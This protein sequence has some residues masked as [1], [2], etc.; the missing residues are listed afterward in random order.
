MFVKGGDGVCDREVGSE[1]GLELGESFEIG[2][3]HLA[4]VG[5]ELE[6]RGL[7]GVE[8]GGAKDDEFFEPVRVAEGDVEGD[9]G[10]HGEAAEIAFF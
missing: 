6:V 10:A 3:R 5:D 2:L 9:A 8:P 7:W 4:S 1:E